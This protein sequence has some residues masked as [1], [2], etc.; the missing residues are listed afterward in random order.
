[1]KAWSGRFFERSG[2]LRWACRVCGAVPWNV[3]AGCGDWRRACRMCGVCGAVPWGLLVGVSRVRRC[4]MGI[5][6]RR[7]AWVAHCWWACRVCGAVPWGLVGVSRVWRGMGIAGGR[8]AWVALRHGDCWW[9]SRGWR[10]AM[11][12]A[13]GR[14]T[15]VAPCLGVAD[16]GVVWVAPCLRDC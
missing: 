16:P 13:G 1:M 11:E 12:F 7:V 2:K 10:C 15:W 3:V 14:V 8:V 5:A 9:A 4:A 6:G